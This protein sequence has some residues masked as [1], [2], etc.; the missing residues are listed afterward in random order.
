MFHN[1]PAGVLQATQKATDPP[2]RD[3][4]CPAPTGAK[5][6]EGSDGFF[7]GSVKFHKKSQNTKKDREK[8][9]KVYMMPILQICFNDVQ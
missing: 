9:R 8:S 7:F 4:I 2:E 5:L 1:S 6:R 3:D